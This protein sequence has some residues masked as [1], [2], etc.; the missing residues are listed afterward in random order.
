MFQLHK[1]ALEQNVQQLWHALR[2]RARVQLKSQ[3]YKKLLHDT[4]HT[5]NL[6]DQSSKKQQQQRL[7]LN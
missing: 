7:L 1:E 4:Q 3:Q 6:L 2:L 5:A